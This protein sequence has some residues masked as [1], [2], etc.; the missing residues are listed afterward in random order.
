MEPKDAKLTELRVAWWLSRA[1]GGKWADADQRAQTSH[2]L[3]SKLWGRS[4]GAV[5]DGAVVDMA[6]SYTWK[7]LGE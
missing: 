3:V 4:A 2:C 5:V 1:A 6:V 7:L